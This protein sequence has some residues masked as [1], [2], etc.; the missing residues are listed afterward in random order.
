MNMDYALCKALGYNMDGLSWALTFYDVNCQY[1]KYLRHRVDESLSQ[2]YI[3]FSSGN[4]NPSLT[5]MPQF[6]DE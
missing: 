5:R 4:V 3:S 2:Y 1:N 6:P